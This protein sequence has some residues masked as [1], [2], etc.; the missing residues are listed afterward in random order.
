MGRTSIR[1][2]PAQLAD[3]RS[4]AEIDSNIAATLRSIFYYQN[5][6]GITISEVARLTRKHPRQVY[7]V[8][9]GARRPDPEFLLRL[10]RYLLKKYGDARLAAM[11]LPEGYRV[12]QESQ[13]DRLRLASVLQALETTIPT[14][15][16]ILLMGADETHPFEGE[17]VVEQ[18]R[19]LC[20][21]IRTQTNGKKP[22]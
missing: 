10:S 21:S 15:F 18:I 12:S 19:A 17:N 4:V 6:S 7:Y 1:H 3:V 11:F 5:T 16:E 13:P 14:L 2:L 9:S 8:V 20:A 22:K